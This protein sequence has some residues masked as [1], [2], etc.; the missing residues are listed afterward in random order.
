MNIIDI[1][2]WLGGPF[3]TIVVEKVL[4]GVQSSPEKFH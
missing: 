4:A 3:P 2:V 1:E